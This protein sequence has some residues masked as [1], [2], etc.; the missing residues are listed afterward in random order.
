MEPN[1]HG[2]IGVAARLLQEAADLVGGDRNDQHGEMTKNHENIASLWQGYLQNAS[3]RVGGGGLA[4]NLSAAD[5]AYMMAL[6]KIAR[7]QAGSYNEDDARDGAAYIC[8][9]S[10]IER[11]E[12]G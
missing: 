6:L 2:G 7:T 11:G 3:R 10:Q 4:F 9:G 1:D 8:I 12:A 5:V